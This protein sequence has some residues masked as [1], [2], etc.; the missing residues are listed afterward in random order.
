MFEVAIIG[1]GE[2][3]GELARQLARADC[4][5]V[6]RLVDEKGS[7]AAGKAL[8]IMQSAPILGFS[9]RV[10][11]SATLTDA[12]G[13]RVVVLADRA[14]G[15]E[16]A[17][18]EGLALLRQLAAD[19]GR[20]ILCAGAAQRD[21][22]ERGARELRI[23]RER[24]FGSAPEALASVARALVALETDRSVRDVSMTVLGVPPSH[25]VVPW[26]SAAIGGLPASAI[27]DAPAR[28]RLDQRV[29]QLWPPG[30]QSLAAAATKALLAIAGRSRE[31]VACFVAPDDSGGRRARA[32]ALPARLG[33]EGLVSADV[34]P[35]ST[36]E[37]VALDSAML[38]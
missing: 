5:R 15:G 6:I 8:D 30:P 27:I 29:V 17:G 2:L 21:L 3:G 13:A 25:V 16:W 12:L 31:T 10:A 36:Y 7:V 28:R 14:S 26:E 24:L 33:A 22:V 11:G 9:S 18:D 23:R 37:R 35:L 19:A 20:L 4:S 34:P 1:A 38:V 32:A